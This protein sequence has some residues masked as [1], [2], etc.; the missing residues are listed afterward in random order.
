MRL[1]CLLLPAMWRHLLIYLLKLIRQC[2]VREQS[3]LFQMANLSFV[4]VSICDRNMLKVQTSSSNGT[5]QKL[6][7]GRRFSLVYLKLQIYSICK[8][9]AKV[10]FFPIVN[11]YQITG[12][13]RFVYNYSLCLVYICRII[14]ASTYACY[15]TKI[16]A[17]FNSAYKSLD[18]LN[19]HFHCNSSDLC[20]V[21]ISD[22]AVLGG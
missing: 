22:I 20:F 9:C 6:I 12:I 10:D 14:S 4:K 18:R 11:L 13:F 19:V 7:W 21:K 15:R 2:I 3:H 17:L 8:K 1:Q 5:F 16:H